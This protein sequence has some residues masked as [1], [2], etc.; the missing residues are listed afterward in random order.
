MWRGIQVVPKLT[1][2]IYT[3]LNKCSYANI[4]VHL[5]NN[6]GTKHHW[7]CIH[8]FSHQTI[9]LTAWDTWSISQQYKNSSHVIGHWKHNT[10]R[11][12][13][14]HCYTKQYFFSE[15]Y[16]TQLKTIYKLK[17]R[18]TQKRTRITIEG[19]SEFQLSHW[20]ARFSACGVFRTISP[21]C[22]SEGESSCNNAQWGCFETKH[23]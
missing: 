2:T 19:K 15:Q 8:V 16:T 12:T 7:K 21:R 9:L 10:N 1:P 5:T 4:K 11:T 6:V 13:P 14:P 17:T 3:Y 20:W 23:L 22:G 18:E